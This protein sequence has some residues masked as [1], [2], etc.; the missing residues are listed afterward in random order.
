MIFHCVSPT[1]KIKEERGREIVLKTICY[2]NVTTGYN[3]ISI[4]T[5]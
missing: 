5:L 2:S 1:E 4:I 3:I